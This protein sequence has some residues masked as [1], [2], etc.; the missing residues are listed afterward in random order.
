MTTTAETIYEDGVLRLLTPVPYANGTRLTAALT[1]SPA[2]ERTDAAYLLTL[3]RAERHRILAAAAASAAP[4]YEADLALPV[5]ERELTAFTA[6]DGEP[7][8]EDTT[9]ETHAAQP[10]PSKAR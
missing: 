2:Q 7:F 8:L 9:E 1:D 10:N 6:L 3:P 4:E 5:G